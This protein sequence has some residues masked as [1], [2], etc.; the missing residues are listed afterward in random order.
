M[1]FRS[2]LPVSRSAATVET[3]KTA[4]MTQRAWR[5]S[6]AAVLVVGAFLR[7]YDL[8]LV[9]LHHDE[10]VNGK[11]LWSLVNRGFYQYDPQN[12]HGPTLY[13]FAAVIPW[14]SKFLFGKSFEETYGLSTFTI[15]FVTAAFGVATICLV[16]TLRRRVGTI[17]A[18]SGA[19]LL[20]IS[21]GAVYLSRYFIHEML[22]VFFTLGVVI[23]ALRFYESARPV[24]LML[25]AASAAL[26]FATKETA[27]ISAGVLLIAL[28]ST[29]VFA[30][31]RSAYE[32]GS[33]APKACENRVT[34]QER[35]RAATERFGGPSSL[36]ILSVA[37]VSLFLAINILFYSSFF[38]NYPKGLYD[39]LKTFDFWTQTGKHEHVRPWST[40]LA[41][42]WQEESPLLLLGSAG[43]GLAIW[44]G[45][46]RF[47]IFTA[48]WAFGMFAAYSLIPYK[49]P[50]LMLN[51]VV[52]LAMIS[53]YAFEEI[54]KQTG[55]AKRPVIALAF[56]VAAFGISGYQTLKLNFV[57]YD[58]DS[59][60]YVYAHTL[61]DILPMLEEIDR[62]AK[63]AGTGQQTGIAVT[64][65]DYWPLP[66]Y[67]RNYP[68]VVYYGRIVPST[69]PIIIGSGRQEAEL[70]VLFGERYQLIKSG[71][72]PQGTY[73]L[74]SGVELVLFARRDLAAE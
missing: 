15:R 54:C 24:Y 18:L 30:W 21:P 11:F 69:E 43:M 22:L 47:V 67:L 49:T 60:A 2:R 42:M 3:H 7:L 14:I 29:A 9:P 65:P 59:Y 52:P 34:N 26:M 64:S 68:R 38:T 66:W 55:A 61:R 53:G 8:N 20:A 13:Y 12:Y 37:A 16:L 40:Y 19:T 56:A 10:G 39:A 46:N 51:F 57:R 73:S 62:I 28:A 31:L 70:Q 48:L 36:A 50:W 58:D 35:L 63:R 32:S 1:M 71:V 74:R 72:N 45:A 4:E 41:W 5:T 44:R 33:K 17:A 23:A 25:A 6:A 27:I